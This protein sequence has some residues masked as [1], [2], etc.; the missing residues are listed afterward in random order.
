MARQDAARGRLMELDEL[1]ERL[2]REAA[3]ADRAERLAE[4]AHTEAT[5]GRAEAEAAF[6]RSM[7]LEAG[8]R[9]R[10]SSAEGVRPACSR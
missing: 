9:D 4:D 8:I 10:L 3:E 1:I 2:D 6:R 5:R 7:R